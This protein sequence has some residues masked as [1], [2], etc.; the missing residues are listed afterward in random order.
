MPETL[1]KGL[2]AMNGGVLLVESRKLFC[3]MTRLG[4]GLPVL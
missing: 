4:D 2:I 1:K 3:K